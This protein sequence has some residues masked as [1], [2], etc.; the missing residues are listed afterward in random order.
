MKYTNTKAIFSSLAKVAD[1]CDEEKSAASR[2][3]KIKAHLGQI[4][5]LE[6]EL[7]R[8]SQRLSLGHKNISIRNIEATGFDDV[9]KD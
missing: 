4:K 2:D 8:A 1:A 9:V 5:L 6:Y 7:K 3:Q